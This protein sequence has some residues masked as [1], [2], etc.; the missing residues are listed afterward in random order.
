[1][2]TILTWFWKQEGGRT[3]YRPAHVNIWADM[4]RRHLTIPH[5][6]ACVTDIPEGIDRRIK[7]IKPPNDFVKVRTPTWGGEK[8]NCFR[9]LSMFRRDAAEIFGE[10]FVCMDTDCVVSGSLDPLFSRTEDLILYRGTNAKR[11]YNGS[12]MLITAG[13][14]PQVVERFTPERAAIAGQRFV[15]SDQSWISYVLGWAEETWGIDDGVVWWGSSHVSQNPVVMFF[16]GDPK[17]WQLVGHSGY[18]TRHYRAAEG[19]RC[20]ILSLGPTLWTD[21]AEAVKRPYNAV[22]AL[23]EAA[24][25]W[26]WPVRE[27][28]EDE[29]MAQAVVDMYGF[30]EVV[31]CGR[32]PQP[33]EEAA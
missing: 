33:V 6:I 21:V 25:R 22:V 30:D 20:L 9:R 32:L 15:G 18:V 16:P 1:M 28:V 2:L 4:V 3:D 8:P 13:C 12:M 11:P 23:P 19:G 27:V 29:Y 24:I 31:W 5:Q 26:P 17:P 7:I 10:R 14:R